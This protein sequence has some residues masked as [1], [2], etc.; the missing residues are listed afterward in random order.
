MVFLSCLVTMC[1]DD[2]VSRFFSLI[3]CTID[4]PYLQRYY[5]H[6]FTIE[7][8]RSCVHESGRHGI[9]TNMYAYIYTTYVS[10]VFEL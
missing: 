7:R 8:V 4:T 5:N 9:V 2:G 10:P 6:T 1:I 3:L